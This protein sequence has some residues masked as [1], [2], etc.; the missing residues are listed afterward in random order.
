M[1]K[2]KNYNHPELGI[3][4]DEELRRMKVSFKFIKE[5]IRKPTKEEL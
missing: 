3:L 5:L 1:V 2:V 4:K